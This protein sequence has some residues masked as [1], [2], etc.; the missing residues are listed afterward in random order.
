MR[1]SVP[2]LK[3]RIMP[4]SIEQRKANKPEGVPSGF[5]RYKIIILVINLYNFRHKLTTKNFCSIIENVTNK[6]INGGQKF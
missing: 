3:L 4:S 5:L 1:N 6:Y 2:M